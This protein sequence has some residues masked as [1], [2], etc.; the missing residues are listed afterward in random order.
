MPEGHGGNR[1]PHLMGSPDG[2]ALGAA[3]GRGASDAVAP[4][5]ALDV[6]ALAPLAAV[7]TVAV[8]VWVTAGADALGCSAVADAVAVAER[9]TAV[10]GSPVP[11]A[12]C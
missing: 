9:S 5:G 8:A 3:E 4:V 12:G 7:S 6:E 1:L 10:E 2:P 11:D